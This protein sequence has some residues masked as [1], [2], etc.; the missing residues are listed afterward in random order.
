[1]HRRKTAFLLAGLTLIATASASA[2]TWGRPN[3]PSSGACFYED[4]NFDGQ[5]FCSRTGDATSQVP[6]DA[7]DRISS[8]RVFGNAQVVVYRDS[9]FRGQSQRFEYDIGDLR[10]AGWNDL[11]SSFRVETRGPESGGNRGSGESGSGW[12]GTSVPSAGACFYEKSSFGGQYFC[13]PIGGGAAQMPSGTNDKVSSIRVY[14]NAAVTVFQDA[15]FEGRS[16]RFD[17]NMG[18]L[19]R[20][21]WNDLISSFRVERGSGTGGSGGGYGGSSQGS[22]SSGRSGSRWTRQQAEE[23]VERAYRSVLGRDPDPAS[24]SWVDE[25]MKHNW[26]EQQLMA[27]LRK[28]P[29]Y[30]EQ[31]PQQQQ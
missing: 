21:G 18:D 30:R 15:F 17:S 25:V 13:A 24:R 11:I 27:E 26:S 2:Q 9:R 23:M 7:D 10:E 16:A 3:E 6:A 14:G 29:E 4:I 31:Q 22:G 5:Y 8:I 12:G 1:M 19:Q 28:T 20:A